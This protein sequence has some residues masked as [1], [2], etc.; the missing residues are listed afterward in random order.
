MLMYKTLLAVFLLVISVAQAETNGTINYTNFNATGIVTGVYGS[1]YSPYCNADSNCISGD[2][3]A[4][5]YDQTSAGVYQGWCVP[6]GTSCAHYNASAT[7]TP[8]WYA[9]GSNGDSCPPSNASRYWLCSSG[10]WSDSACPISGYLC[11]ASG[12]CVSNS[13]TTTTVSSGGTGS[14]GQNATSLVSSIKISSS[15]SDFN[16]TQGES[17]VKTLTVKN[18][19]QRTLYD[20]TLSFSGIDWY[21][22]SPSEHD[23]LPVNASKAFTITFSARNDTTVKSHTVT[24]TVR[25]SNASLTATSSFSIKVLPSTVTVQNI[26]P[27]YEDYLSSLGGF[28]KNITYLQEKGVNTTYLWSIYDSIREKLNQLNSTLESRDYFAASQLIDSIKALSEDLASRI[29]AAELPKPADLTIIIIVAV[30]AIAV[31][32]VLAYLFWPFQPKGF[33]KKFFVKE[34]NKESLLSKIRGMFRKKKKF[35]YRFAS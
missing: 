8:T 30:A 26:I 28:E 5:D 14:S 4:R 24:A 34:E 6:S 19:G 2:R 35:N 9:T 17:A 31:A 25:T 32:G 16:I 3:C 21:S 22:V 27:V 11:G 29:S 20:V 12:T 7:L 13:T 33:Q 15:I 23:S 18:D 1:A 10:N